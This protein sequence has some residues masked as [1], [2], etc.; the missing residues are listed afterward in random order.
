MNQELQ[1]LIKEKERRDFQTGYME[2][3]RINSIIN[4]FVREHDVVIYG[5][6]AMNAMLPKNLKFYGPNDFPDFDCLSKS[7]KQIA[8]ALAN[9]LSKNGF[10]YTEVRSAIH[11]NTFK[12][13]VNFE[14]MADFT[15][16]SHK[17]YDGISRLV[18]KRDGMKL[19]PPFLLKHY[20]IKELARPDG[21]AFRWQKVY[22]RSQALDKIFKTPQSDFIHRKKMVVFDDE[23]RMVMNAVLQF[24]KDNRLPLVG[25]LGL[26]YLVDGE[27]ALN[28][29]CCKQDQFFSTFEILSTDP[30]ATYKQLRAYLPTSIKIKSSRRFYYQEIIPKRLRVY[31]TLSNGREVK[32]MTIIHTDENCFSFYEKNGLRIGSP[33]TILQFLYAYWIVYYVY[34]SKKVQMLVQHLIWTLENHIKKL[35]IKDRFT[36]E[37]YGKEKTLLDVK[38]ERWCSGSQEFVYR[39]KI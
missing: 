29:E 8:K 5:G 2:K 13:F 33:Y 20:L 15:Q 17:F 7:A 23:E 32:L 4:T 37:C 19:A 1:Q 38:R 35:T 11:A 25:N 31:L 10:K 28:F 9:E 18:V 26:A 22:K 30:D 39:P 27:K 12:V 14:A 16:V 3:S 36:L 24:I 34:E 6:V 21:S